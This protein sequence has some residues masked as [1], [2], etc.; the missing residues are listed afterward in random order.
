MWFG[1]IIDVQNCLGLILCIYCFI[2]GE[3]KDQ[4][5]YLIYKS[6]EWDCNMLLYEMKHFRT[7]SMLMA[8]G[9]RKPNPFLLFHYCFTVILCM[10]KAAL[11]LL[12]TDKT[13]EQLIVKRKKQQHNNSPCTNFK[14]IS[15]CWLS[16]TPSFLQI[17]VFHLKTSRYFLILTVHSS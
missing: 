16:S 11:W 13:L 15:S 6:N 9:K 12:T 17:N 2:I 1:G 14:Q 7:N 10:P 3:K 4:L 5:T 8:R